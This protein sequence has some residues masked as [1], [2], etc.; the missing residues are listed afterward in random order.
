MRPLRYIFLFL[1]GLCSPVFSQQLLKGLI[2]EP[3]STTPMP[4]VYVI[5]KASGNGTMSDNSGLF[6][7]RVEPNDTLICSFVGYIKLKLPVSKLKMNSNGEAKIIMRKTMYTL[8]V[9][10]VSTFK[11]K[12]YERDYMNKVIAESKMRPINAMQSPIT[13]L[14]M[15]YSKEG[16]QLQKLS[17]IF[18]DIFEEEQVQKKLNPEILRKLTGDE[19]IDYETFRKY[20]YSM[21]NYFILTHDGYDLYYKVME[22][23]YRWKDEGRSRKKN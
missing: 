10:N 22:C 17:K 21:S 18:E 19:N 4:F 7:L 6:Y 8:D 13:A 14:Y 1:I 23:Y 15:K 12:P 3:D 11:L 2:V 16:K 20:C 9:V 5:S